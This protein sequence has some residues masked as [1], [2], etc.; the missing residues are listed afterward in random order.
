MKHLTTTLAALIL[1]L[2]SASGFAGQFANSEEAWG[3]PEVKPSI[4]RVAVNQFAVGAD[5]PRDIAVT[6]APYTTA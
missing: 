4:G 5:L 2:A 3:G 1:G 6:P